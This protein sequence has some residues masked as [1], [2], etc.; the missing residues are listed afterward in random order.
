MLPSSLNGIILPFFVLL[1]LASALL[2]GFVI[3]QGFTNMRRRR[4]LAPP[5]VQVSTNGNARIGNSD[6]R[7][8]TD[9]MTAEER[10][11]YQQKRR[12]RRQ[13]AASARRRKAGKA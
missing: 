4:S 6:T 2:A 7:S 12:E 10:E 11:A 3:H 13:K 9:D 5:G 8:I 1:L